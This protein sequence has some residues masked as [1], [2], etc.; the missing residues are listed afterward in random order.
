MKYYEDIRVV[1]SE[2]DKNDCAVE[3]LQYERDD[4]V[5]VFHGTARNCNHLASV[6]QMAQMPE[7]ALR[8]TEIEVTA[9]AKASKI[10]LLVRDGGW[11]EVYLP[12]TLAQA[13]AV[14]ALLRTFKDA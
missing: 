6:L 1:S 14:A 8:F 13:E 10:R 7:P 9:Y 11:W 12:M 4:Y 2:E 5:R 3:V